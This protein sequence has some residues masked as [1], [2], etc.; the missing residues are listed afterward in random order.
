[1]R[2]PA[3][4][5]ETGAKHA[6]VTIKGHNAQV[7]AGFWMRLLLVLPSLLRACKGQYLDAEW[8]TDL[9]RINPTMCILICMSIHS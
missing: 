4:F 2:H 5:Q 3:L 8:N 7:S 9:G 6:A 1:M